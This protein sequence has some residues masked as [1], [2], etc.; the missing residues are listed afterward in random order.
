M[1]L[2]GSFSRFHIVLKRY[3]L[4]VTL[5]YIPCFLI[6]RQHSSATLTLVK[7]NICKTFSLLQKRS[8]WTQPAWLTVTSFS[9]LILVKVVP[10]YSNESSLCHRE[11]G[12][13]R[14]KTGGALRTR[15]ESHFRVYIRSFSEEQRKPREPENQGSH[16]IQKK[17]KSH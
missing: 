17:E 13:R 2:S 10:L 6:C 4:G 7:G 11:T 5:V 1:A 12:E 15:W 14:K 16:E 9:P 8:S 3:N